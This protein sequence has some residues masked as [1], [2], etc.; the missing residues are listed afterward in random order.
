MINLYIMRS[1]LE[2]LQLVRVYFG[3]AVRVHLHDQ[4][5]SLPDEIDQRRIELRH[6]VTV[7]LVGDDFESLQNVNA[8]KYSDGVV[9]ILE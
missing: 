4:I 9:A 3:D 8:K 1:N 6:E 5:E 7:A 2:I